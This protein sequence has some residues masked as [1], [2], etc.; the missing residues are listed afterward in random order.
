MKVERIPSVRSTGFS[1]QVREQRPRLLGLDRF[2]DI[3]LKADTNAQPSHDRV[4]A[5]NKDTP[6]ADFEVRRA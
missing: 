5:A 3:N 1:R 4:K 2:C 6:H